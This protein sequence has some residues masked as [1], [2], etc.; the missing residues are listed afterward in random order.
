MS[1]RPPPSRPKLGLNKPIPV[2]PLPAEPDQAPIPVTPESAAGTQSIPAQIPAQPVDTCCPDCQRHFPIGAIICTFCAYDRRKGLSA[3]ALARKRAR[4]AAPLLCPKCQYSLVGLTTQICPECGERFS[5]S[6]SGRIRN[7][8]SNETYQKRI[9]IAPSV[10]VVT[11]L[12]LCALPLLRMFDQTEARIVAISLT[13]SL[14][15]GVAGYAT[16]AVLLTGW[17]YT[18][19]HALYRITAVLLLLTAFRVNTSGGGFTPI[20]WIIAIV[21]LYFFIINF[22]DTDAKDAGLV[23]MCMIAGNFLGVAASVYAVYLLINR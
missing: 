5:L 7:R 8:Q 22:L 20:I 1:D 6:G 21:A 17:P 14:L 12:P 15:G 11:A 2:V 10:M 19:P 23:V 13:A 16:A 9:W 4:S 3:G 18:I